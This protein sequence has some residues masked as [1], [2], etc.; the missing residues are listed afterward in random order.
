MN[1]ENGVIKI[2]TATE[3]PGQ[4][5]SCDGPF[6][7][8]VLQCDACQSLLLLTELHRVGMCPQCSNTRVRNVRTLTDEKMVQMKKLIA[9]HKIDPDWIGLFEER[10][11]LSV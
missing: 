7:E 6:R 9:E 3:T 8:P 1:Q 4:K 2:P 5:Y 11:V 10:E